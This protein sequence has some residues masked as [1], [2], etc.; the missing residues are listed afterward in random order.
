MKIVE[1][2]L[3]TVYIYIYPVRLDGRMKILIG[4]SD[5]SKMTYSRQS[6]N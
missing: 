2:G 5:R 6:W 4:I 1:P 3:F